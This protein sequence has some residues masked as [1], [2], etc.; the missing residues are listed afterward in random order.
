MRTRVSG[1]GYSRKFN[2][3][4]LFHTLENDDFDI[5]R[6][7]D[8]EGIEEMDHD[9]FFDFCEDKYFQAMLK[10]IESDDY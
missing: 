8:T 1:A 6:G 9:K 4:E 5:L 10:R 7:L 2:T 3:S